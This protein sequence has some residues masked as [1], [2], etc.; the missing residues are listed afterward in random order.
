MKLNIYKIHHQLKII[1]NQIIFN[2]SQIK[3]LKVRYDIL[4]LNLVIISMIQKVVYMV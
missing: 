2:E 1:I 4:I 3:E